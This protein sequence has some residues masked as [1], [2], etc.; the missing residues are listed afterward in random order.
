MTVMDMN[1]YQG[2]NNDEVVPIVREWKKVW[3]S[4]GAKSVMLSKLHSGPN[5]GDW[6]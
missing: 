4:I 3:E 5:T 2:G 6:L 1:R